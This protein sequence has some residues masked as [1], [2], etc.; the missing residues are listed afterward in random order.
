MG[1]CSYSEGFTDGRLASEASRPDTIYTYLDKWNITI[2]VIILV[3]QPEVWTR[4]NKQPSALFIPLNCISM[5]FQMAE[6]A[7]V[8]SDTHDNYQRSNSFKDS[9]KYVRTRSGTYV[10]RDSDSYSRKDSSMPEF[11]WV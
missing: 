5:I 4:E 6:N 9:D 8:Q 1:R 7:S 2:L 11:R 10:R 3:Y